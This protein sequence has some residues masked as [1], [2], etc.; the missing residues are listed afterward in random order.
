VCGPAVA[1][2]SAAAAAACGTISSAAA[3]IAESM[4]RSLPAGVLIVVEVVMVSFN[5][6]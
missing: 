1:L 3:L 4:G 6:A 5:P 2:G